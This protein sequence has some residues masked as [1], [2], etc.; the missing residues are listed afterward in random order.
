MDRSPRPESHALAL[1]LRH[2]RRLG[3]GISDMAS[4]RVEEVLR[5]ELEAMRK[6]RVA[7]MQEMQ[8]LQ[9]QALLAVRGEIA[10]MQDTFNEGRETWPRNDDDPAWDDVSV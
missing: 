8:D 1:E 10:M 2:D 6:E 7:M 4:P 3:T 5:K 9:E